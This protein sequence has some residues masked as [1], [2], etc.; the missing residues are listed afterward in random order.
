MMKMILRVD[1]VVVMVVAIFPIVMMMVTTI[2]M[3]LYATAYDDN[4]S[5]Y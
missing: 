2:R 5:F 4:G 1:M 3:M